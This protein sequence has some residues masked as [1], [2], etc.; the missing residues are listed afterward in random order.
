MYIGKNAFSN[1]IGL[2][3]TKYTYISSR[4]KYR[5]TASISKQGNIEVEIWHFL[6]GC[7]SLA[8]QIISVICF[9]FY[10]RKIEDMKKSSWTNCDCC[11][12]SQFI[13][14]SKFD[15]FLRQVLERQYRIHFYYDQILENVCKKSHFVTQLN[16]VGRIKPRYKCQL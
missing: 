9:S 14:R 7:L 12:P 10:F 2:S 8:T 3:Q 16:E 1:A 15:C 4:L 5:E 6:W 11:S 13:V